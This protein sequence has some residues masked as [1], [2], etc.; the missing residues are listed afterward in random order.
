MKKITLTSLIIAMFITLAFSQ[1]LSQTV[2]G[3]LLDTDSKLPLIGATVIILGTNPL[4]GTSTDV[5][6]NFKFE[7]IAIG[8]IALQT[9]YLGYEAKIIPD[10]LVNSGKESVI[11]ISMQ[12][13]VLKLDEVII[14][15]DRKKGEAKN[16]MSLLSTHSI[17][18]EE[19]KRYTGGMDDPA[20]VVSSFAGVAATPDGSSDII[21]RGNSPKY[22]QWR[23]E[24]VEISSPYHMDDQNASFG[25][26]T[27]LNNNLLAT[28][29][30]YTGAFSPEYGDVL[31]GVYDVKLRTGNNEKF[32]ATSGVGIMGTDLTLEGPF[33]KGYAGS[34]LVSY[35][36]STISLIKKLGLV[37]VPGAVDYQD[38]TFKVVLPTKKAGTFSFFGLGGSSG[39]SMKNMTPSGL[40]TPGSAI[41][42]A[43]ISRDFEK[44]NNLTNLGMNH[45]YSINASS[46]IKASLSY[47]GSGIKDDIF[48]SDTIRMRDSNGEFL[49]D[50]VTNKIQSFK[51]RI[52]KS[53]YRAAITYNNKINAKNKIQ[54]GT[55][56]TLYSY[57]FNQSMFNKE[58]D[59]M[60]DVT[61][62]KNNASVISNFI[63]WKHSLNEKFSFVAGL[64][65][66]NALINGKSTIE[67]RIA[68]N[69]KLN[70]S[71]SLHAGYGK[72]STIENVQNYYTKVLQPDGSFI[73]PNK[74]LDFLKADHFVLGYEKRFTENLMA[75]AEFY[76]QNLY[77]LPVEKN[78]TSYYS[79][80]NEGIDYKYVE[81]VNKGTG[82]NYGVEIS[83][84]RFFDNNF[85]FLVNGSLFDSKYK[86]LEGVWRNTRYNNNYI[87]NILGGKEFKN[88][89]K[90][91]NQTLALNT[92]IFFEGGQRYIPLIRNAQGNVTVEPE[93]DRYFDYS[94]AYNDKLDNIFLLNLSVSYKF[95]RPKATH[96][97]FL[98]LMNITDNKSR[99]SEYYDEN[100]PNK[101]GYLTEFGF[102]PNLMYKVYF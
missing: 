14:K 30:F 15:T 58:A 73:E 19:T 53:S 29:D 87:V 55:K 71:N 70:N 81:L 13:S 86:S 35:R 88:I 66:T 61:N 26:L 59:A 56:Y 4:I 48:E 7:K 63:S 31:S 18:L 33:K 45:T 39:V 38:A 93:N 80:I 21:V 90:K 91:H 49:R 74:N 3:T 43:L 77:N 51:N 11:E 65:N 79:T 23:L 32:E 22:V 60:I 1:K 62:F 89:G 44:A 69:W 101:T 16:D 97:I 10:I 28:S 37:D 67:P 2:R 27:A 50:S 83:I 24:G 92:K 12:E 47:S 41:K 20:R 42:S 25:A 68:I 98:D 76:Y 40:S 72:H 78:D 5:N 100:K 17:S 96:E 46:F 36:Y 95:N 8:R 94:K 102:F 85:Y 54:I 9:S 57:N 75:K 64:H 82:K 84:E 52:T 34:Y 6:G 99:M